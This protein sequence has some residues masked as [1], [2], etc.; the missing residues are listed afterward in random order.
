M[1]SFFQRLRESI[2]PLHEEAER[3]GPLHAIVSGNITMTEYAEVLKR[4]HGFVLPAERMIGSLITSASMEIDYQAIKRC[5]HLEKD[6]AFLGAT[7]DEVGKLPHSEDLA[8]LDTVPKAIGVLYLFEGSRLGGQVLA[9]CL[10]DHFGFSELQ[11]Y[12]YFASNGANVAILW[13]SFKDEVGRYVASTAH[14]GEIIESAQRGFAL[15][16]AW[17]LRQ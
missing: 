7:A 10:R 11:G 8:T 17:L 12:A 6:L 2:M 16:N 14:E 3:S 13:Q 1:N 15:L 4:L 5:A 9:K